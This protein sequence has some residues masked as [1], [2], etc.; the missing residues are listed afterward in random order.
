MILIH[1]SFGP[2]ICGSREFREF[3]ELREYSRD[4]QI[5][6]MEFVLEFIDFQGFDAG[7][8]SRCRNL[9]LRSCS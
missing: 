8:K 6:S 9:E 5:G 7:F 4:S 3:R 1:N 2:E